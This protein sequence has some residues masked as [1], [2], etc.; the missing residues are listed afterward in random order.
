MKIEIIIEFETQKPISQIGLITVGGGLMADIAKQ[1]KKSGDW[2]S[3]V[4]PGDYS[5]EY[6]GLTYTA[7]IS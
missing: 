7:K 3:E 6:N 4:Q 1:S 5:G 2:F